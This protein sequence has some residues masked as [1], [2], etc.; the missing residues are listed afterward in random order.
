M[1]HI[2]SPN[3]ESACPV[4][5]RRTD[6]L[7][8]HVFNQ[9]RPQEIPGAHP[10]D[11]SGLPAYFFS[12]VVCTR[13]DGKMLLVQEFAGQGFWLPGGRVDTGETLQAA[14]IR[15]CI[16]EAGVEVKLTGLLKIEHSPHETYSRMRVIFTATLVGSNPAAIKTLPVPLLLIFCGFFF[17][18][19]FRPQD[20]TKPFPEPCPSSC[21]QCT[22]RFATVLCLGLPKGFRELRGMLGIAGRHSGEE[23]ATA[24]QRAV[25][26]VPVPRQRRSG[27]Q[28]IALGS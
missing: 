17:F 26:M 20:R 8:V 6:N 28:L 13:E 12:L 22:K 16:E 9:H 11:K 4:C 21:T 14:A 7:Q 18:H 25:A 2:N 27:A 19:W 24:G 3:V 15:E 10:E 23:A 1:Y 5:K